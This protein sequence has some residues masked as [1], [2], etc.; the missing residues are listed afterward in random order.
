M[1]TP[2]LDTQTDRI[3]EVILNGIRQWIGISVQMT[4]LIFAI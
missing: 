2:L 4:E 1:I 3:N